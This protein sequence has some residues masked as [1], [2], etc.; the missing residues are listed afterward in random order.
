MDCFVTAVPAV[1]DFERVASS[2]YHDSFVEL[3]KEFDFLRLLCDLQL[4]DLSSSVNINKS[5]WH[6]VFFDGI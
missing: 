3:L 1:E 5:H 6:T 2:L 4:H